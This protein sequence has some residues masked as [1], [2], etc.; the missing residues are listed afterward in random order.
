MCRGVC[1][2]ES[3]R[4]AGKIKTQEDLQEVLQACQERA[5]QSKDP[6]F[7]HKDIFATVKLLTGDLQE[8]MKK[9]VSCSRPTRDARNVDPST[10]SQFP[11]PN[12]SHTAGD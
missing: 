5:S 9:H 6:E 3:L 4:K 2:A 7:G 1:Y 8:Q 10:P 12:Q 11:T